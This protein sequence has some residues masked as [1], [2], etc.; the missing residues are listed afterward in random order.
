MDWLDQYLDGLGKYRI[1]VSPADTHIWG[2]KPEINNIQQRLIFDAR[3][4]SEAEF[5]QLVA[6]A[7]R[8]EERQGMGFSVALGIGA[9]PGSPTVQYQDTTPI[10][11]P[12]LISLDASNPASYPGSGNQWINLIDSSSYTITNGSFDPGCNGSIAFLGNTYVNLGT[13]LTTNTDYTIEAWI[14]S[15]SIVGA[16]NIVST[17]DS[18]FW[19]FGSTLASGVGQNY[20]V[21]THGSFPINLW[22]YVA[23]TFSDSNNTMTLYIDGIQVSQNTSVTEHFVQQL[24]RIGAH[25]VPGPVSF[26][27]GNIAKVR[28]YNYALTSTQILTKYTSEQASYDACN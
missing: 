16:R 12:P 15:N 11:P 19:F 17:A 8:K 23:V 3:A 21:V 13:P 27:S 14:K 6:E 5:R 28:I 26:F 22:K 24:I 4:Q 10:V 2:S 20:T 1:T 18:P 7:R 25:S 9:D